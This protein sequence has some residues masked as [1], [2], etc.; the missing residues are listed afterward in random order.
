MLRL[1][2]DF[3][4]LRAKIL[5]Q[6]NMKYFWFFKN[7]VVD[8]NVAILTSSKNV[9]FLSLSKRLMQHFVL[10]EIFVRYD[11]LLLKIDSTHTACR[12]CICI[13]SKDSDLIVDLGD[14]KCTLYASI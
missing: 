10:T 14:N 9:N 8:F 5:I 13:P 11:S 2:Q 1:R 4:D 3:K 12:T 6:L 7:S